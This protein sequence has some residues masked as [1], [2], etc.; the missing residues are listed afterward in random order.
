M[1][2]LRGR[3]AGCR[4][5]EDGTPGLQMEPHSLKMAT[6]RE[7]INSPG[8][9]VREPDLST[10]NSE[11]VEVSQ[12]LIF[13]KWE[14]DEAKPFFTCFPCKA[15]PHEEIK[16]NSFAAA[17][18]ASRW[19]WIPPVLSLTACGG[20]HTAG[21]PAP[22]PSPPLC[23]GQSWLMLQPWDGAGSKVSIPCHHLHETLGKNSTLQGW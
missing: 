6:A 18:A 20:C 23:T 7:P 8:Q 15:L 5:P 16:F 3:R 21:T 9:A 12:K 4:L 14:K 19:G 10:R 17:P 2:E 1:A 22:L 11:T 13:L